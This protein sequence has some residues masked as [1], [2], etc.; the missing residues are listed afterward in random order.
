VYMDLS[1]TSEALVRDAGGW[2]SKH[3][4]VETKKMPVSQR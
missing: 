2:D 3:D 4:S 1:V